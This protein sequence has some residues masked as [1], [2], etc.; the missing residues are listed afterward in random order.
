M[1]IEQKVIEVG[2][3]EEAKI[4]RDARRWVRTEHKGQRRNVEVFTNNVKIH[5]GCN[6]KGNRM[7]GDSMT[8]DKVYTRENQPYCAIREQVPCPITGGIPEDIRRNM[9]SKTRGVFPYLL[10]CDY[11]NVSIESDEQARETFR[12]MRSLIDKFGLDPPETV[13]RS[14]MDMESLLQNYCRSHKESKV[15]EAMGELNRRI[16]TNMKEG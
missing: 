8:I 7:S 6:V 13:K 11:S 3:D 2:P 4:E 1:D 9:S 10:S 15:C 12:Y 16:K 14:F 5:K